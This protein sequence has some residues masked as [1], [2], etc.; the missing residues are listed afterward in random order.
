MLARLQQGLYANHRSTSKLGLNKQGLRGLRELLKAVRVSRRGGV[1]GRPRRQTLNKSLSIQSDKVG[2]ERWIS[3][4]VF[5]KLRGQLPKVTLVSKQHKLNP[6]VWKAI[7]N[8]SHESRITIGE[9]HF[10]AARLGGALQNLKATH[11]GSSISGDSIE[12]ALDYSAHTEAYLAGG[13][14]TGGVVRSR[15]SESGAAAA[16]SADRVPLGWRL[17]RS[18]EGLL[19]YEPVYR[20]ASGIKNFSLPRHSIAPLGE[21]LFFKNGGAF[22][23]QH[24]V[25]PQEGSGVRK[26]SILDTKVISSVEEET[27]QSLRKPQLKASTEVLLQGYQKMWLG[28]SRPAGAFKRLEGYKKAVNTQFSAD[29]L[30]DDSDDSEGWRDSRRVLFNPGVA[31]HPLPDRLGLNLRSY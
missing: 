29:P 22:Q 24:L 25:R 21:E 26:A 6:G 31:T 30:P 27:T 8:N 17:V 16:Y 4:Q 10:I 11:V 15:R 7:I 14:L 2:T 23:V 5:N 20:V 19:I 3:P 18:E 28:R 9:D 12:A 13:L 1:R